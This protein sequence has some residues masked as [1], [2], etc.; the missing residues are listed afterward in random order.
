MHRGVSMASPSAA[1]AADAGAVSRVAAQPV[2]AFFLKTQYGLRR[3]CARRVR[4]TNG[5]EMPERFA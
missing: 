1:A 4:P 5:P 2:A 3:R